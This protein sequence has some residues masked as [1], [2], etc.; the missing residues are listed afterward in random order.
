M[1]VDL[2]N[3]FSLLGLPADSSVT[4]KQV[5]Q[6]HRKLIRE[7]HPDRVPSDQ[8]EQAKARAADINWANSQIDTA[9]KR[10]KWLKEQAQNRQPQGI[11]SLFDEQRPTLQ[12]IGKEVEARVKLT[13]EE[14][15]QGKQVQ[16][17]FTSESAC[18]ICGGTGA[19]PGS[20]PR[21]CAT[22][23]GVGH[24]MV[25]AV[26]SVCSACKGRRIQ[27]DDPCTN[28]QGS[29]RI[30]KRNTKRVQL[31]PGVADGQQVRIPGEGMPGLQRNGDL[32]LL[33]SVE[34]SDIYERPWP[35]S[36][37]LRMRV[38]ISYSEA[39]QGSLITIPTPHGL[40]NIKPKP[41]TSSG[42]LLR[43]E[44]KG[45]PVYGK[46]GERGMLYVQVMITVPPELNERQASLIQQLS[47]YDDPR[48]M[49][50]HLFAAAQQDSPQAKE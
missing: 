6:A 12:R 7:H 40:I 23:A 5:R 48:Q 38:P 24:H 11:N 49:R 30:Q 31:L 28:C 37:D 2:R 25:G 34:K 44:D 8:K 39:V 45:A 19:K 17:S 27:V 1:S 18:G 26:S 46:P 50:G 3:P 36:A 10:A 43:I 47:V 32:V 13:F 35:D 22:C 4:D 9:A 20:R 41:G 16:V 33:V 29:G 14:A 15:M 21:P 42:A